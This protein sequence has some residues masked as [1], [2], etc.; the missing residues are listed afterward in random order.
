MCDADKFSSA[1]TGTQT[2]QEETETK[3]ESA[4]AELPPQPATAS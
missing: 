3:E 1:E 2:A 4:A